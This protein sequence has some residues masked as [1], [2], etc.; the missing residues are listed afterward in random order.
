MGT[1]KG[2]LTM[3]LT[4]LIE[5]ILLLEMIF[6]QVPATPT[7]VREVPLMLQKLIGDLVHPVLMGQVLI[8]LQQQKLIVMLNLSLVFS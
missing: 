6:L 8:L 3:A 4:H 7:L 2:S 5:Q 1:R